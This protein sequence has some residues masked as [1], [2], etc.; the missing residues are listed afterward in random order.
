MSYD[1]ALAFFAYTRADDVAGVIRILCAMAT[2]ADQL[3]D[4]ERRDLT[5]DVAANLASDS[6]VKRLSR[7]D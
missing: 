3:G 2:A 5:I 4:L 1:N 6:R 7:P